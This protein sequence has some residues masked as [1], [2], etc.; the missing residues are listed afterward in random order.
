MSKENKAD[1][2]YKFI[3]LQILSGRWKSGERIHD[4]ELANELQVSRISVREALFRLTE[5]QILEKKYWKGYF[6]IT[7]NDAIIS[8]VVELRVILETQ[9]LKNFISE[10][11]S[12]NL[13]DLQHILDDS[14]H[15]L[16]QKDSI[17]YLMTDYLFH[18]YIYKHQ[19]NNYVESTM[20]NFQL[21]IHFIRYTAMDQE[22]FYKTGEISTKA[23][24]AIFNAI[25]EGNEKKALKC[26]KDHLAFHK[27]KATENINK[28]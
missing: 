12:E 28:A 18:E 1:E 4:D 25:K 22:T 23:H 5:T 17:N 6:L 19:H 21:L 11:T 16:K 13:N 20:D 10:A 3:R 2:I 14:F 15:Y 9:A 27:R 7:L 26:L 8:N 24:Q